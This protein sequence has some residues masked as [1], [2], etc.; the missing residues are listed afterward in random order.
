VNA[1]CTIV[2]VKQLSERMGDRKFLAVTPIAGPCGGLWP[3]TSRGD[4]NLIQKYQ[5]IRN[6]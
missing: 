4:N 2:K 5:D 1:L 6:T 3:V